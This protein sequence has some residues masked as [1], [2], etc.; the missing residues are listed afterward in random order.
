MLVKVGDA[1]VTAGVGIVG[2]EEVESDLT[3]C[4]LSGVD[5]IVIGS[6]CTCSV[7]LSMIDLLYGSARNAVLVING[8]YLRPVF[9][10]QVELVYPQMTVCTTVYLELLK[11]LLSATQSIEGRWV[12]WTSRSVR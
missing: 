3:S 1:A 5:E 12:I 8:H 9:N 4:A 6:V 11:P 7:T 2:W 10:G